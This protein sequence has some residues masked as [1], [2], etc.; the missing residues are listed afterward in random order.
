MVA[1]V[2][3]RSNGKAEMAYVGAVP[4]HGLVKH[5]KKVPKAETHPQKVLEAL[6]AGA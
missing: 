4:W 6:Q 3:V 5:W 1:A 2:S